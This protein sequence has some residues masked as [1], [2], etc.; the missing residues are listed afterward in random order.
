LPQLLAPPD[1]LAVIG[2]VLEIVARAWERVRQEGVLAETHR[3]DE[4]A[5]AGLLRQR[6]VILELE[7]SPRI[8]KMKIKPEV[9]VTAEDGRTVVGSI[10]IEVIY[11][12]GD[13]PDLRLE[14]KRVSTVEGDD[15][16]SLARYYV[17]HGVLRFVG[18]YGWGH[19]WGMMIG[20]A[21]DGNADA[22]ALL[23]ARYVREY[24]NEPAHLL[25]DWA[26]EKRFGPYPYLFNT[27]HRKSGDSRIE[28]LHFFL[29]FPAAL[30]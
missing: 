13:E 19:T 6:M 10:D 25:R 1:I 3:H 23:I 12:L 27:L 8:P 14:C 16:T 7:R 20:F 22:A 24:K 2:A 4:R 29:P 21:I 17:G 26:E 28:L 9:G 30:P 11:S 15:P 5:T 18:K